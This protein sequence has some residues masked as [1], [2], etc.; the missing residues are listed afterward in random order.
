MI[1]TVN[2][3]NKAI[4]TNA[5]ELIESSEQNYRD[6]IS[7][8][9]EHVNAHKN[10]RVIMLAGPSASGKTTTAHILCEKLNDL[11]VATAVVS[12]D[13]FY[14][15][16][17]D[18]R[19]PMLPDGKPNFETV[20][21][22]EVEEIQRCMAEVIE[23]GIC[24][25]PIFDFTSRKR[26]PQ[27]NHIDVGDGVIIIEGLHA[28]NPILID[29][30]DRDKIYKIY[31]SVNAPILFDDGCLA[32]SSKQIRLIRRAMRDRI[33]RGADLKSTLE[34]WRSVVSG[35]RRYLYVHKNSADVQLSTLHY[36]EPAVYRDTFIELVK[37]LDRHTE[38]YSYVVAAAEALEK[39]RPLGSAAVPW[40]SLI[41]EFIPGGKYENET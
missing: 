29:G 3:I 7:K 24:D 14:L 18:E 37:E 34:I 28:L 15:E 16:D 41:R 27:K 36:Y 25:T 4:E 10:I 2:S 26:K 6:R 13:N 17:G 23:T 5:A 8:I 30:I 12:L 38:N 11:G 31:I 1:N 21:A 35:E 20:M 19:I 9:A 22:L 40:D 32:L 33:Y 39:F